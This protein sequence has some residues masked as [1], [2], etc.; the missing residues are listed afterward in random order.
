MKFSP[1]KKKKSFV[2][3]SFVFFTIFEAIV[4]EKKKQTKKKNK[5]IFLF[6]VIQ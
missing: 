1:L 2:N 3:F 4:V 5:K 6:V